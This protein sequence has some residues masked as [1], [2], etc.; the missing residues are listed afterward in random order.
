MVTARSSVAWPGAAMAMSRLTIS[1]M[2]PCSA[3]EAP[4]PT[5][6]VMVNSGCTSTG[7]RAP[8]SLSALQAVN[9]T[10]TAALSSR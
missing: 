5:S 4:E 9:S 7:G 3:A 6:S 2:S 1:A 10:A 8:L